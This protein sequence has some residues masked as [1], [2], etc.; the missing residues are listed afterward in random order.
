LEQCEDRVVPANLQLTVTVLGDT[1]VANQLTLREAIADSNNNI[2][3]SFNSISFASNLWGQTIT[4]NPTQGELVLTEPVVIGSL[5]MTS[6]VT[7]QP[8]PTSQTKIRILHAQAGLELDD[9]NLTGGSVATGAGGGLLVD[10]TF[11]SLS[12]C[13]VSNNTAPSGGGLALI[14]GASSLQM[15]NCTIKNNT[16]TGSGGGIYVGVSS[17][18]MYLHTSAITLNTAGTNGGGIYTIAGVDLLDNVEVGTNTAQELG[19]GV[20][21]Q[22]GANGTI[23]VNNGSNIHDNKLTDPNGNG[24]GIYL[25]SGALALD[26]ISFKNNVAGTGT[27][28]YVATGASVTQS[29]VT[30]NNNSLY[31]ANNP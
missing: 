22:T 16:A 21:A 20:Y 28:V 13:T 5:N 1:H 9:V 24:G 31:N 4:L 14:N 15:S 29:N 8:D 3:S 26:S 18:Q 6:N 11:A 25:F 10:G 12:N 7:V 19:G 27:G 23:T 30:W 17:A 2:P